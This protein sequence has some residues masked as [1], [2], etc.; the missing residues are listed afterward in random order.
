MDDAENLMRRL[1]TDD[2]FVVARRFDNSLRKVRK[3]YP[4]GV[5]DRTAAQMLMVTEDELETAYQGILAKMR[6][7]MG[8]GDI[9]G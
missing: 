6:G 8:V 4:D 1:R 3:R 2:D 9:S 7:Q 5:P